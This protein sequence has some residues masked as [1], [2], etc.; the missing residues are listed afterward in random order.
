MK[1]AKTIICLANSRKP[2]SGRCIAGKEVTAYG[3]GDWIRPVSA[4]NSHEISE[5]ERRYDSGLGAQVLDILKIPL[6]KPHP[7]RH[8]VENHVIAEEHWT[9][10]DVGGW[11]DLVDA[12]DIVKGPIWVNGHSTY[13][14]HNDKV[15]DA[16]LAAI[17]SSLFLIRISNVS[18]KVRLE[19]GFG[20][21]PPRRRVRADFAHSGF[22]YSIVVT[23]PEFEKEYF[24]KGDGVYEIKDAIVCISL[25]EVIYGF[26]HKLVYCCIIDAT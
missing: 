10:K 23:D 26:A 8:Q 17:K 24:S 12:L 14:G 5:D 15:P 2:P 21:N 11:D 16:Q 4:R 3:Y 7:V 1:Y 6:L 22:N 18:M 25:T 20:D 19:S 13:H 9:K